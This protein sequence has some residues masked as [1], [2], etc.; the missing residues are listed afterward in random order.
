MAG[1]QVN[2]PGRFE[3]F[4]QGTI[5]L[6][7]RSKDRPTAMD[8]EMMITR[9]VTSFKFLNS[10]AIISN[11]N[12]KYSKEI[13]ESGTPSSAKICTNPLVMAGGQQRKKVLVVKRS[14]HKR[15]IFSRSKRPF[16]PCQPAS[17]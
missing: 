17:G 9:K 4:C 5:R 8:N 7:D 11:H 2:F 14:P 15:W 1:F 12:E 6:G 13:R 16:S 3:G 10:T